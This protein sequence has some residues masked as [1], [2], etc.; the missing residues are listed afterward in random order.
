MSLD[1]SLLS[2][3]GPQLLHGLELTVVLWLLGSAIAVVLG[4]LLAIA[5]V[6]GGP[7]AAIPI[8][9]YIEFFRGTPLLV[10]LFLA[11][12]GGP[13]IG[14]TLDAFTVG[15]WGLGLYGAAY[16]AEIFRA[17]LASIP[18]GQVEAA[19]SF[20]ISPWQRM[21]RIIMPQML[22]LV[23]PPSTNMLIIL[24]KDTAILSIVTVPELTF[25]ITGMTLETFA[26]VEPFLAL[27][28]LY[29]ALTELTAFLGRQ[30]EFRFGGYLRG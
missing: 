24:M 17:G 23:V 19:R 6:A 1:L 15:L 29:W 8:R 22:V 4:F 28:L 12:Y 13:G 14:I 2:S 7:T 27:A 30:A 16:F 26:F 20:G 21:R 10:Q 11:Y 3:Y 9:G 25:Q 5:L 18:V